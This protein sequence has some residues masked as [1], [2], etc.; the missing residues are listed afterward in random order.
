LECC[1][2]N[3]IEYIL[4][5]VFLAEENSL[6]DTKMVIGKGSTRTEK[7]QYKVNFDDGAL[8]GYCTWYYPNGNV[9]SEGDFVNGKKDSV[10]LYYCENGHKLSE[11]FYSNGKPNG[12][13]KYF[14]EAGTLLRE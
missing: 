9:K 4:M 10:H 5:G 7:R 8:K 11:E 3:G 12:K 1:R 13:C 2:E 14:N 6:T